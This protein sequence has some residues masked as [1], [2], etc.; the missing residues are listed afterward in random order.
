MFS[1]QKPG[2]R[3]PRRIKCHVK[4]M[5]QK[6]TWKQARTKIEM[7]CLGPKTAAKISSPNPYK[8]MKILCRTCSSP[9]CCSHSVPRCTRGAKMV[10]QAAK[11][12]AP[13]PRNGNLQDLKEAAGRRW[14]PCNVFIHDVYPYAFVIVLLHSLVNLKTAPTPL[15][16][17]RP[18]PRRLRRQPAAR[19]AFET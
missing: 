15:T 2:L 3:R 6:E 19:M 1:I 14:S 10:P 4:K 16:E 8:A 13:S 7:S 5:V 17:A 9:S 11:M 18:D 12:E